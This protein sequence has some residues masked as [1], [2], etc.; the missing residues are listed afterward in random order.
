MTDLEYVIRDLA[1]G[2]LNKHCL[3]FLK[4][5]KLST[6]ETGLILGIIIGVEDDAS[7]DQ[8][9]SIPSTVS[10]IERIQI[11]SNYIQKN[12]KRQHE[13]FAS[14]AFDAMVEQWPYSR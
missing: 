10:A 13:S 6:F 3:D 1:A 5:S 7:Y 14:L 8:K 9:I 12:P 11:I 2:T 4:N